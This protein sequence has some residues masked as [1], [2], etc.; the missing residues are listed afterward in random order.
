ML[1]SVNPRSRVAQKKQL[2]HLQ[3]VG[4]DGA[5]EMGGTPNTGISP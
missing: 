5:L 1:F 3:S 4:L 2:G